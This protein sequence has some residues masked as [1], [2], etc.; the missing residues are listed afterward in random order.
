MDYP[1]FV[2]VDF[3]RGAL[4]FAE[5]GKQ[6]D[7]RYGTS[8]SC[9]MIRSYETVRYVYLPACADLQVQQ[10]ASSHCTM[11]T[12]NILFLSKNCSTVRQP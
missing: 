5:K 3:I 12:V 4:K 11:Y 9:S 6:R 7:F 10:I 2:N 8:A 1:I